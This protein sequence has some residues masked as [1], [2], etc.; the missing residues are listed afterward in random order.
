MQ[1]VRVLMGLLAQRPHD[2]A[3]RAEL[4]I[5]LVEQLRGLHRPGSVLGEERQHLDL[6]L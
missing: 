5:A 6:G 2:P 1:P 3:Q 4:L